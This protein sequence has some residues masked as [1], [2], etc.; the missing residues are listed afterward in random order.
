VLSELPDSDLSHSLHDL[1]NLS[2]AIEMSI[3]GMDGEPVVSSIFS[4]IIVPERPNISVMSKLAEGEDYI[5]LEEGED[6]QLRAAVRIPRRSVLDEERMLNVL[7]PV[8][9]HLSEMGKTVQDAYNDYTELAYLRKPLVTIFTLSLSLIVLLTVLATIWFAIWISRRIVE[10]LQELAEGT[11]AVSSGIY[12]MQL[13]SSGHDEIGFLVRSFNQMTQRLTQARNASQRSHRLLEQQTSYL[14]TVLSSLSS[15]VITVDERYYLH[16]A[17]RASTTILG[18]NLQQRLETPLSRLAEINDN[19]Q[20]FCEMVRTCATRGTKWEQQIELQQPEGTQTLICHGTLLPNETGWV[21]VFE[22]ISTLIQ[23]HR[24]AAWGEVAR[25]LAHE[26]KNPLTPIQLSAERLQR[27]YAAIL[28]EDQLQTMNKLTGTIV[29]QVE[30]MKEMVDEFSDY[31]RTPTLQRQ[32][33]SID[34]LL[35]EV[36]PLYQGHEQHRFNLLSED[37]SLRV[38]VD[39][40]RFRQVL[41]NLFK[42]AIEAAEEAK[43]PANVNVAYQAKAMHGQYWLALSIQD[44]GP[45]IPPNII[46]TLFE[47]YATTKLKG[48]G[49]GLAI[50]KKIVEEHGG[51]VW[52]ENLSPIGARIM[53]QLPLEDNQK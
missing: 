17:N 43:Q 13:T 46:D 35:R 5:G 21:V 6:Y 27:K 23:A 24:Y 10:P 38:N 18:I 15:G 33:L 36:L 32:I 1:S 30:A 12:N 49:L 4:P 11:Q 37:K 52:A 14:T 9:E 26:I 3:W 41:H 16:T 39:A 51:Q 53:I 34:T 44:D 2:G 47:P 20:I 19:M 25:R 22:D 45:G 8:N 40:N 48:T 28:P 7:F 31:A 42:N 29:N 50:V